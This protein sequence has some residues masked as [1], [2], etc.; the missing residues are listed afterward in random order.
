MEGAP[1][2]LMVDPNAKPVAHHIPVPPHWQTDV[3]ASLDQDVSLGVLEPVP[4]REPVTWCN[5]MVVCAKKSGKPCRTVDFQALNL[6]ATQKPHHTQSPFHQARYIP[7]G[8]KKTVFDCW[9]GYHSVPLHTDDRHLTTFITPWGRYRYKTTPRGYIASGDG[10]SRRFDEIVSHIPDKT[11]CIDDTLLW[12]DNLTESFFQAVDWLDICGRHGIT[13]NPGKFVFGHDTVEFAGFEIT[14]NNVRRC[15]KYLD[16]IRDFPTPANITYVRSCFGLINQVSYAFAATERMLPFRQLLKPGT[17][18]SWDYEL[19]QLFEKSKSVIIGEIEEGIRIF[20]KSKP[21]CL[22]TDWSKSGIGYWLLQKHCQCL[23]TEPFCCRTGWKI[24]LVGS[25]FTHAAESRYA[26]VQGE[27]LAVADALDKARFS[28]VGCSDLIIAVDHKPLLKVLG[29]RSLEEIP[30][31]RLR[32]LK[33]K[34]LRFR[35][36]MVHVPGVKHKAA[37]AVSRHPTGPMN[38]DMLTLPDDVAATSD[39][40]VTHPLD[41]FGRSFLAGIRCE[42]PLSTSCSST[43]DDQLVSSASSTLSTMAVTWDRVKLAT[44]SDKEMVQLVSIIESGFPEFRNEL[45]PALHE[46]HQYTVDGVILYKDRIVIPPSL[47]QHVLTVLHYAHQ[48]VISMTARAETT[49]FWPGITPTITALRANCNHCNRMA[50][51][52]PNAPPS[53]SVPPA[54]PFQ[55]VCADFFH[56]KGVNYL[57][58]VDRYSNWPIIERAQEGAKGL[59]DC[60]RRT[61]G[62]FGIPDECATDGGPEFTAAAT[63]QFLKK[64]GVH[65]RLSSVAFPHSNCR[66]EVGVKTVKRLITNNTSPNGS[67]NTDAL[68]RTILQ[69][70]NTPDPDTKISPAQCVFD[71]PIKYFIPILPGRYKPHPTWSDTLAAR[72]EALRN[73]HMRAAERWTEHTSRLPPLVVGD[74]VRI[75]NQT[76]SHPIKWDKTGVVIEVR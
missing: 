61:F 32:N 35:F 14:P 19:N 7:S 46:Y 23:S 48:G 75:Q 64:W 65:H 58:V 72:E 4:V 12:A 9:N 33:E 47:R 15:K 68:H 70:R 41:P 55:C 53:P 54:Y 27:A 51:S 20:D 28:V 2:R 63:F 74:H 10:N 59:I 6:H 38:P 39:S 11:K 22:A 42:E 50:P 40:I 76:S 26:P 21:T 18:F 30:N 16:A 52:Q 60:L 5:R 67:L 73:R 1:M 56:Y 3:K 24:T 43:I 13:L 69:Y 17:P 62:T 45:P 34:T 8:K 29:D 71:R 57:V 44:T 66:A 49:V 25:R 37:D 36:R 31:A